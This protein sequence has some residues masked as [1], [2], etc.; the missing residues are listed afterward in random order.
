MNIT[1]TK[2]NILEVNAFI[3]FLHYMSNSIYNKTKTLY[4]RNH[5]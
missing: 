2:Q 3:F 4:I 1:K 5:S